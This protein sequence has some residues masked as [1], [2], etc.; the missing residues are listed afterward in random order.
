[1][2][3]STIDDVELTI[4]GEA[5][6][7]DMGEPSPPETKET[8][9]AETPEKEEELHSEA[10]T[11]EDGTDDSDSEEEASGERPVEDSR[12]KPAKG[13]YVPRSRLNEEIW[14]KKKLREELDALKKQG[15]QR[16]EAKHAS[17]SPEPRPTQ[18]EFRPR[19]KLSD[20]EINYD[21]GKLEQAEAA[22]Y[23]ELVDSKVE[24]QVANLERKRRQ[25]AAQ[26][27]AAQRSKAFEGKL[28]AYAESH[29]DYL[30]DYESA[31]D[32]TWPPHVTEALLHSENGPALDHALLK[33]PEAR[34]RIVNSSPA[35]ALMELG[36]LE[37]S[38][39][40]RQSR[41]QAEPKRTSAP[42]PYT[43]PRGGTAKAAPDILEG[44]DIE[45]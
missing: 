38:I 34:E 33:D 45:G 21:E 14:K 23:S 9:I 32:P 17:E 36:K 7:V 6:D 39:S 1:M 40:S 15:E 20:P 43:Q 19:P 29:P 30:E 8:A 37:A 11:P 22:W 25:E 41:K 26:R 13:D 18:V 31:G 5:V 24:A 28:R 10:D 42:P 3:T 16:A 35:V 4:D 2:S 12:G 27:E 44:Y